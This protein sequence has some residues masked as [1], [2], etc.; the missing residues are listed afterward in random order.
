MKE[1]N[2]VEVKEAL[3]EKLRPSGWANKLKGFIQS[4]D[5]TDII[6]QLY[7]LRQDGI[8]FTPPLK[9]MF[10]CFEE[11]PYDILKVVMLSQDP[12]HTM[13]GT[14]SVADGLAFSCGNTGKM[15]PSLSYIL[16]SISKT[17]YPEQ[18]Y[19]FNP[20]LKRWANQGVLLFN[21]AL[22]VQIGKPASHYKIWDKFA[23][24]VIDIISQTNSG[25]NWIFLG[26]KAQEFAELV[27]ENT[28][29]IYNVSHPP[30]TSHQKLAEWNCEDVFNQVNKNIIANNGPEYSILW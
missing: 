3:I 22:S 8:K 4:S 15:Q 10:R 18:P 6:E 2:L 16:N 17:V 11:C 12:Y 9:L 1:V 30:S 28:H 26:K 21:A 24:Y 13:V 29:Y 5:F 14:T 19:E 27:N 23:S 20:D 7:Q 25:I